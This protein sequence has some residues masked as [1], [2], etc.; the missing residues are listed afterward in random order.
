MLYYLR[1]K[2]ETNSFLFNFFALIK[3]NK[4][5]KRIQLLHRTEL[6]RQLEYAYD[7]L[8]NAFSGQRNEIASAKHEH[9]N[10]FTQNKSLADEVNEIRLEKEALLAQREELNKL[11]S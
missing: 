11:V 4:K 2:Y 1:K 10:L 5:T 9:D 6:L 7:S 3:K 8:F